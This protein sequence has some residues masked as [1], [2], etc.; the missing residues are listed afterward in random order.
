MSEPR[1][2]RFKQVDVFTGAALYGNPLAVVL[3]ADDL[4]TAR[5]QRFANWTNLS[6]TTFLLLPSDPQADYKVR[7]F[8]PAYE[9]PFAGHPTLGSCHARLAAGGKP[10]TPGRI[11][12]EC[13]VGLVEI[14]VTDKGPAFAAPPM[15]VGEVGAAERKA[16]A[17]ALRV[18]EERVLECALLDNGPQWLAVRLASAPDAYLAAQGTALDRAGRVTVEKKDGRLWV[19]GESVICVEGTATF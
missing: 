14:R 19:G 5:M 15:M 10:R 11:V 17:A 9:M 2:R 3:D 6:E 13:G 7:I 4:D 1:Q 12:Q 8:T 18:P 16:V